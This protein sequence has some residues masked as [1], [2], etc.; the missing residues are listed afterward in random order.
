MNL[1]NCFFVIYLIYHLQGDVNETM[2]KRNK[3]NLIATILLL[4]YTLVALILIVAYSLPSGIYYVFAGGLALVGVGALLRNRTVV[5]AGSIPWLVYDVVLLIDLIRHIRYI[6]DLSF[7]GYVSSFG[8]ILLLT[9]FFLIA[10]LAA[11][12]PRALKTASGK[13][14][15][16]ILCVGCLAALCASVISVIDTGEWVLLFSVSSIHDLILSVYLW[17]TYFCVAGI[18]L[19]FAAAWLVFADPRKVA[20]KQPVG[21]YDAVSSYASGEQGNTRSSYENGSRS[22]PQEGVDGY[23]SMGKHIAL[24][25]LTFGVWL[26]IWIYRTTRF[27]N[28]VEGEE[29][30]DP[31]NKLLLCIFVPFYVIYWTYVSA[32]R[33]DKMAAQKGSSSDLTTVCLILE[34]FIPIVPPMLMQSKINDL[35]SVPAPAPQYAQPAA[36]QYAQPAAPQY[37][38]PAVTVSAADELKK[39]KELLDMGAITEEEYNA[40]KKQLLNL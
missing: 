28:N 8:W 12:N 33:I 15:L 17:L 29:Y 18:G 39:Y 4:A 35:V 7:I 40:K 22:A 24:L 13:T 36:P 14:L 23:I 9:A 32:K 21:G 11:F 25:L 10:M 27:L 37:A 20:V 6:R 1:T 26:Y 2:E 30:R 19:A 31:T 16:V 34:F 3:F 5:F 38:Q